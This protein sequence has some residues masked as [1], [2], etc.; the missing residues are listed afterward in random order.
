MVKCE[1]FSPSVSKMFGL[2]KPLSPV[3][4]VFRIALMAYKNMTQTHK[5]QVRP[6]MNAALV[7][8]RECQLP[9]SPYFLQVC[10]ISGESGAGKTETAKFL[11]EQILTLCK[12]T[13]S[14]EN[15]ILQVNALRC[16]SMLLTHVSRMP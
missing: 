3:P 2:D 5:N 7:N 9:G 12:G 14:L 6:S 11:V 8:Q 4:H 15:R 16:F 10:V 13:G 1:P